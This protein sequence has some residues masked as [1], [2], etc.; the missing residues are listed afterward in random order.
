MDS[1]LDFESEMVSPGYFGE[2]DLGSKP[3]LRGA[4]AAPCGSM[5]PE[6]AHHTSD[7]SDCPAA[8]LVLSAAAAGA[9]LVRLGLLRFWLAQ[10]LGRVVAHDRLYTPNGIEHMSLFRRRGFA[11]V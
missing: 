1:R 11:F 2:V 4:R 3:G 9:G 8:L 10:R 7:R 5:G 6:A